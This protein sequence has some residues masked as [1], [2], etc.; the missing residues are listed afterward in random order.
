MR[1]PPAIGRISH[2]KPEKQWVRSRNVPLN[3]RR[4]RTKTHANV[5]IVN[6]LAARARLYFLAKLGKYRAGLGHK[7]DSLPKRL[8]DRPE[9]PNLH[10]PSRIDNFA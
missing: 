9:G 6:H 2:I 5:Y 8:T 10:A 1:I 4:T 7:I 3:T